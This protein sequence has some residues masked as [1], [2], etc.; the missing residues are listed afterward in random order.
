MQILS[1]DFPIDPESVNGVDLADILNRFS[2]AFVTTNAGPGQPPDTMAGMLWLDTSIGANGL[3]RVRNA[4]N[5]AWVDMITVTISAGNQGATLTALGLT[6]HNKLIVDGAGSVTSP[7]WFVGVGVQVSS[8]FVL[9]PARAGI[10]SLVG[11]IDARMPR[12]GGT[13]TGP[14]Y[15]L[16]PYSVGL[17][18]VANA[19]QVYSLRGPQ[20]AVYIGWNG[21]QIDVQIDGTYFGGTWPISISGTCGNSNQVNGIGGWHYENRNYNPAYLWA[22]QGNGQDQFLVQPGNLNVWNAERFQGQDGSYWLNNAGSAVRNLRN[23]GTIQMISGV[24]GVG[25][26]WWPAYLSDARLKKEVEDTKADSLAQIVRLRFIGYRF[27]D[28]VISIPIDDG[29]FH[30]IGLIAQE[31]EKIEPEW[32][33]NIGTWKQLDVNAML[34]S[35]LHAIQQLNARVDELTQQVAQ[36]KGG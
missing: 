10:G 27:R 11:A 3:L 34:A 9:S 12:A 5:T 8:D 2:D 33:S 36:L 22:T 13:F 4:A 25:D 32:V 1:T 26:M 21:A 20:N 23:N 6:N 35:A 18:Q 17:D 31:A 16:A 28:D 15:G 24:A 30:P 14:V 29:H 7:G 19:R